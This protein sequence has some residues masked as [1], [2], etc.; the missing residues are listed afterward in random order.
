MPQH[1]APYEQAQVA[2]V[3]FHVGPYRVALEA[4]HVLAMADH[5]TALRT[6]NAHSLLYADGEHDSP[7]SHWL[8]LRDAQKASDDNSTWQLGVSG[9]ITLQQLPANTLYPLPKLLHSRRFST[10]L[11]GFTFDQQ[12]LVMLLDARK[13]NL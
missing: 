13:L 4:R 5:P 8:T 10:A 6:A 11:C 12:Q 7:P 3:L 9:D 1:R 2:L